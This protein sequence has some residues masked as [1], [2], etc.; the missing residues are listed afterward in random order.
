ME[1]NRMDEIVYI[2][3]LIKKSWFSDIS[4]D[5][6]IALDAWTNRSESNR[7]LVE[8]INNREVLTEDLLQL[9]KYNTAAATQLIFSQTGMSY[10]EPEPKTMV[11][12][13]SRNKILRWAAAA[14]LFFAIAGTGWYFLNNKKA[15]DS[16]V[17]LQTAVKI[18]PGG[19]KAILTLSDGSHVVLDNAANGLISSQGNA[20]VIKLEDGKLAYNVSSTGNA[21]KP[22]YNTITTPRG[23]QYQITLPDGTAVWL[24]SASSLTFP[25]VFDGNER[26]VKITGEAYFEVMPLSAKGGREK[27]P[28]IV[29]AA[30][31]RVTVLGTH[32]NVNAYADE[33]AVRTTL[34][35]GSIKVSS[36]KN[37]TMI[38]PGE[39]AMIANGENNY[40]I[41]H[42]DLEEVLAWKNGRFLFRNA[43]AQ[44]IMRQLSRWYDIDINCKDDLSGII[45]SGGISRKDRLEKLIELLE[46]EGRM[47]F[48]IKGRELTAM[49]KE[50]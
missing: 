20:N 43:N 17:S 50:K 14:I 13:I 5:E 8:Q 42:P 21:P 41:I 19:N 25:T 4:E 31:N 44:S 23:G 39:Q 26:L 29:D 6:K 24:N 38:R 45:F 33:D 47:K 48:E 7:Q 36:G 35:E 15:G 18:V 37:S 32:F 12:S 11:I 28:F 10:T 30:N 2:A 46:L 34:V 22:V 49:R 1:D 16:K 9:E 3:G 40:K 27:T